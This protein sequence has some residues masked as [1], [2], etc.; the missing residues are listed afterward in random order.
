[1]KN[2]RTNS[3]NSVARKVLPLRKGFGMFQ[4]TEI[5]KKAEMRLKWMDYIDKE[6]TVAKASRHFDHPYTTIKYW[7]DRYNRY[8]LTSL[9][10]TSSSPHKVRTSKLTDD[11]KALIRHA[12]MYEL[13]G[14]GKVTLQKFIQNEYGVTF[15]QSAIQR[16]INESNLKRQKRIRAKG[17]LR[18]NR[19]HM[20]TVPKKYMRVPGGL[21]YLDV[22]HLNISRKKYYQFTAIDHATRIMKA[23]IYRKI[24][25]GSTV[26][27]M[28]YL[29]QEFPFKNIQYIGTDN[30]SEFLGELTE[31]EKKEKLKHVFS[32]PASPRQNPFVERVIRTIKDDLLDVYGLEETAELQQEALENYVWKYNN[33]RPHQGINLLTPMQMYVKLTTNNS[34]T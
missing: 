22:K 1:M 2:Y 34:I 14:S 21:V 9:E 10:D 12:R 28:S 15:G 32:S 17:K 29:K 19:K 7:R 31:Y 24:T 4:H 11:E 25:G 18:V 6:N 8:D 20:Y 26:E 3:C 23:K 13:P 27:F 5:S 33:K 16:V 30:G